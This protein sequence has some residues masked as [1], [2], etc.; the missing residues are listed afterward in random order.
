ADIVAAALT[1]HKLGRT[2]VLGAGAGRLAYDIHTQL[3]PD[4]TVALD[5]NPL[6]MIIAR[7]V[8][9]GENVELYEFPIAPRT[10]ADQAV[11]RT[12]SVPSLAPD[13]LMWMLAD[14]HR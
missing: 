2:L 14:T 10:A 4:T 13:G 7:R 6:L 5:F 12:L 9:Q 1:D 3:A 11:L 8:T